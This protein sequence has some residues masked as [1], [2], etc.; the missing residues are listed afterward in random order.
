[1]IND[2][3]PY[4]IGF[5]FGII[6]VLWT[7]H[8]AFRK[9]IKKNIWEEKF[10]AYREVILALHWIKVSYE[11]II[12]TDDA[13]KK[14]ENQTEVVVESIKN[15]LTTVMAK[16]EKAIFK[17]N[18]ATSIGRLIFSKKSFDLLKELQS[19]LNVKIEILTADSYDKHRDNVIKI[20]ND[21]LPNFIEQS[22]QDL[23]ESSEEFI[24]IKNGWVIFYHFMTIK[25][26]WNL[27][28]Q[29]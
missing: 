21:S 28:S 17:L 2:K 13:M 8:L 16:A 5:F 26:K 27:R 24:K 23:K 1:M 19:Q 10:K 12:V 22:R 3:W 15:M 6:S 9:D 25:R 11:A 14:E 20:I 7:S 18:E 29:L 4:I